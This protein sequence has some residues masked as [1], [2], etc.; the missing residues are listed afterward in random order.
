MFLH[1]H[2]EQEK[3]NMDTQSV[4]VAYIQRVKGEKVITP[5]VS[6]STAN[7]SLKA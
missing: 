1:T 6:S 7:I 2:A 5:K 4:L 3:D